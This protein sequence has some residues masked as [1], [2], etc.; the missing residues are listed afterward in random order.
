MEHPAR[1]RAHAENKTD[2]A[3]TPVEMDTT[4]PA[5]TRRIPDLMGASS[6]VREVWWGGGHCQGHKGLRGKHQDAR[7]AGLLEKLE[8]KQ[9]VEDEVPGAEVRAAG[10]RG[11]TGPP[12]P[13]YGT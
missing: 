7:A 9:D 5:N 4:A 13:L 6:V 10:R 8:G 2:A 3:P 1:G 12:R 11:P